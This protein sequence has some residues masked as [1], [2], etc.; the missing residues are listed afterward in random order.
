MITVT[1]PDAPPISVYKIQAKIVDCTDQKADHRAMESK[2]ATEIAKATVEHKGEEVTGAAVL[3]L[4]SKI[5]VSYLR[6]RKT[7][8]GHL[9]AAVISSP[10]FSLPSEWFDG[11]VVSH[12]V[13]NQGALYCAISGRSADPDMNRLVFLAH[14][15]IAQLGARVW[16]DYVPSASNV[17]D[18]PTRLDDAA[19]ARLLRLGRFVPMHLPPEWAL[20]CPWSDLA[21]LL[22]SC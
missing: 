9:E 8:I 1:I 4:V 13:D 20:S 19:F 6:E 18:L 2:I 12:Y 11:S 21:C 7:Y 15:R 22:A 16:F 17:A 3:E 10:Y 5:G 14:M